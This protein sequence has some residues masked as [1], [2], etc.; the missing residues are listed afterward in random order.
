M[1]SLAWLTRNRS[2]TGCPREERW[3]VVETMMSPISSALSPMD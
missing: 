2:R 1:Y 3:L